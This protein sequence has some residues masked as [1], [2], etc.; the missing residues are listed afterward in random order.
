[1]LNKKR[2]L[3][4]EENSLLQKIFTFILNWHLVAII[5]FQ[6]QKAFHSFKSNAAM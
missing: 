1:M 6:S 5:H 3:D 4:V 2:S